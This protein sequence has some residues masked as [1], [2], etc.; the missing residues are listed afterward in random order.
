[1]SFADTVFNDGTFN[2]GNYT[3]P[4]T[5][6]TASNGGT[7]GGVNSQCATCG[8]PSQA[9]STLVTLTAADSTSNLDI[10]LLNTTFTF[11]PSTQGS[12]ISIGASVNNF[13]SDLTFTS[14]GSTLASSS[15]SFV[16]LIE[17]DGNFFVANISGGPSDGFVLLSNTLVASNF[18]QIDT[19]TGATNASSHPNFSGDAITL[20]LVV[21]SGSIFIPGF[22]QTI[23][24]D[25]LNF[26]I[27][28]QV[29]E[30]ATFLM[31][32]AALVGLAIKR[33]RIQP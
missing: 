15:N 23:V 9:L 5:V 16:P 4:F 11:D 20:G 1:M 7:I 14:N 13:T 21:E 29:P 10:A 28:S 31:I 12:I 18:D 17:Q 32:G 6:S 30:P 25:N 2:L 24:N 3:N 26:D 8:D 22:T 27:Q 33:K 19:T